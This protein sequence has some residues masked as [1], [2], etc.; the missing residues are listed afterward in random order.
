MGRPRKGQA[1][2]RGAIL[3][4]ARAAFVQEGFAAATMDGI[5]A[6]ARVS[7]RT[8]YAYFASKDALMLELAVE[9]WRRLSP[10]DEAPLR[11]RSLAD[12]LTDLATRRVRVL[13]DEDLLVLLRTVV[14]ETVRAPE[15][16]RTFI[17]SETDYFGQLGLHALLDE[18]IARGRL[19]VT[20]I[21]IASGQF[22]GL[23][24]DPLFWPRLLG[25]RSP[26]SRQEIDAVVAEAVATF[27]ARFAVKQPRRRT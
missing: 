27:L 16:V 26:P 24:L 25:V 4:A 17:S 21:Q 3:K 9:G 2:K 11:S 20:N 22:W 15:L 1:N 19:A 23:L 13:L 14:A 18:E 6:R 8:V 7:K 5:A 10:P 12:R